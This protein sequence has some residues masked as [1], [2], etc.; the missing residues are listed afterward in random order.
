MK[1]PI[2]GVSPA[3]LGEVTVMTV[4]PSIA[5]YP[6]GQ[7]LGWLYS[8]KWPDVYIFRVGNLLALLSIP[9][10]LALYVYRILPW[11]GI[12]YTLTNRR[13]VVR[14]GLTGVDHKSIDLDRFNSIDIDV[15][16]GQAWFHAGDLVFKLNGVETFRLPGVSRPE[17]YRSTCLHSQR[18]HAG[19]KKALQRQMSDA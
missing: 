4:W 17:A 9:H 10:A 12:R 18:S 14:R 16:W 7:F 19:V 3:E 6:S 5:A 13:I 1:Q 15:K 11:V 2:A 8:W